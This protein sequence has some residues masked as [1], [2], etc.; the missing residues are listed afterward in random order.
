VAARITAEACA[1][2]HAAH[3]LTDDH[4]RPLSVVHRDVSPHN[5]LVSQEGTVKVT[6]FGVAKAL[7][8][9]HQV[10]VA[11]QVKGKVAYMAPEIIGSAAFDRR[12]DIFAMGCVL[13]EATTGTM[14]FRGGNDPQVMQ[15]VLKG[16]YPAPA[17]VIRGF[18]LEL[19]AII[20]CALASE[21]ARRFGTAEQMRVA[22]EEWLVKSGPLVTPT[23]LG[24]LVR[25][26]VGP[27]LDKRRDHVRAAMAAAQEQETRGT[28][29]PAAGQ[30]ASSGQPPLLSTP[31]GQSHSG[32]VATSPDA[33]RLRPPP[34]RMTQPT[35]N[36]VAVAAPPPLM[37]PLPSLHPPPRRQ[38]SNARYAVAA[39]AGITFA[40]L[41]GGVGVGVWARTRAA[42]VHAPPSTL[43]VAPSAKPAASAPPP[44]APPVKVAVPTASAP[45][46][47]AAPSA[48][49]G[50]VNVNDLPE[51]KP[52]WMDPQPPVFRWPAPPASAKNPAIPANPY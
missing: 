18:P 22:L 6:D 50:T 33:Y 40:L 30:P 36:P 21:P 27:H 38:T 47:V 10:T 1:G 49:T 52:T 45:V 39:A 31:A 11:G 37:R 3:E 35:P 8:Q 23:H 19:A 7:G 9:S 15:A 44:V 42:S 4:G 29:R 51:A 43:V 46:A 2:L 25:E 20:D 14:P 17:S 16:V 34:P 13:Y 24:N 12:S 26:R 41:I 48:S 32:V 28:V 5:I